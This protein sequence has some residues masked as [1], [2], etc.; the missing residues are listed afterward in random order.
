MPLGLY[1]PCLHNYLP[2]RVDVALLERGFMADKQDIGDVERLVRLFG[3]MQPPPTIVFVTVRSQCTHSIG[4]IKYAS[5]ITKLYYEQH[6][7]SQHLLYG[8]RQTAWGAFES[9]VERMCH[10]YSASCVSLHGAVAERMA[11]GEPGF[12]LADVAGDCLL[13]APDPRPAG[14]RVHG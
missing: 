12:S 13:P 4:H 3:A 2:P 14:H 1:L 5:G 10:H 7:I 6:N 11:L 9:E 8:G